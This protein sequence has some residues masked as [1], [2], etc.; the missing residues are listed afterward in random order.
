[1]QACRGARHL[2]RT[3]ATRGHEVGLMTPEY[4]RP[5]V[6]AHKN[7]ELDAEAMAEAATRPTMR[8]VAV[9]SE[10]QSN[11]QVGRP[12]G[13]I[14]LRL[15]ENRFRLTGRGWT[16]EWASP[17]GGKPRSMSEKRGAIGRMSGESALSP[18][19]LDGA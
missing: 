16:R 3:F 2:G 11:V 9:K 19:S 5:Y 17:E 12:D 14:R 7:D 13:R 4:V 8:F 15:C 6:K 18:H 1:M 10:S